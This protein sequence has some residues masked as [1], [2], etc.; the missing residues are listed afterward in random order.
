MFIIHIECI[1]NTDID[2]I[3]FLNYINLIGI[4]PYEKTPKRSNII[5]HIAL[6]FFKNHRNIGVEEKT[7]LKLVEYIERYTDYEYLL[8]DLSDAVQGLFELLGIS[9]KVITSVDNDEVAIFKLMQYE[10]ALKL[11][12]YEEVLEKTKK[13]NVPHQ[14][15][16]NG[17]I[18]FLG[19]GEMGSYVKTILQ[20]LVDD[21]RLR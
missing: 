2:F 17:E 21:E 9:D 6:V 11:A 5:R 18:S 20:G 13:C 3:F 1:I 4:N 7:W 10:E 16:K 12:G 19:Y 14:H 8:L 15:R